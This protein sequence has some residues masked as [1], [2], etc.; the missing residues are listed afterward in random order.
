M[1]RTGR[2]RARPGSVGPSSVGNVFDF[3]GRGC[4]LVISS[5]HRT[6]SSG[7]QRP[8]VQVADLLDLGGEGRVARHLGREPH[9]LPPRLEAVV[10][11][12]LSHGLR[13][14]RLSPCRRAPIGARSRCSPTGTTIARR[15]SGRS[16][17]ILTTS[18][19]T[20]GGK[21]RLAAASGTIVQAVEAALQEPLDPLADVLLGQVDPA[22]YGDRGRS[23]GDCEDGPA[24][25]GQAQGGRRAAKVLQELIVF[26]RG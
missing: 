14:D 6:T 15:S 20:S 2:T 21:D 1:P 8:R 18:I 13:R 10:Q 16:Q 11:Q 25:P 12:D 4:R 19:A 23:L 22:G 3:R 9:L 7:P 24:S 5:T 17:A 26:L